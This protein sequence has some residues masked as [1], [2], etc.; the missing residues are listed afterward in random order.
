[1]S[2]RFGAL[3]R[4]ATLLLLFG[5]AVAV[6]CM[7]DCDGDGRVLVDEIV[8][9]VTVALGGTGLEECGA[10]DRNLDA[11]VTVDELLVAVS[12]ALTGCPASAQRT[13]V[14]TSDF[15]TGSYGTIRTADH[16]IELAAG[17]SR[18]VNADA[19]ARVHGDLLYI[20]N[21]FGLVGDS[22]Q[23]LDSRNDFATVW[24]CSTGA[25]SNPHDFIVA[26]ADKAYVALYEKKELLV[27]DP[28]VDAT[29]TGFVRGTI[30][31]SE[32]A[33]AD[34]YPEPEALALADGKLY[35]VLQRLDR[36]DLFTPAANG[37]IVVID[38]NSDTVVDVIELRGSNPFT[39][40]EIRDD[41][42][43][44]STVGYFSEDDGGIELVDL[45]RGESLGFVVDEAELGGDV[46]DFVLAS[47]KLG[48]AVLSGR[49]FRNS[50]IAFD[51]SSRQVLAT[52]IGDSG[53]ISQLRA[54]DRG[55]LWIADRNVRHPGVRVFGLHDQI[56]RT[57]QPIDLG[58][59]PFDMVFL[60]E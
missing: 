8:R 23:A 34:G 5:P 4:M 45:S 54:N 57:S 55:E 44:I 18:R 11:A 50:L 6:A 48:Y 24:D 13:F 51:P 35:V 25:G 47:G 41:R 59:P 39:R 42:L 40:M 15:E 56:E 31:L 7:G 33:D 16:S 58:L 53:F 14:I 21:R 20:V 12:A 22:L 3:L 26:A 49:N 38:V 1:M 19:V 2:N 52:L 36:N 29:C 46:T 10:Y 27:I 9:G 17:P 28:S 32:Y 37:R 43:W 30:D 60:P